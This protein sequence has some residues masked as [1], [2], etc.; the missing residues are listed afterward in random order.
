[1]SYFCAEFPKYINCN[2]LN[3]CIPKCTQHSIIL[4]MILLIGSIVFISIFIYAKLNKEGL[5]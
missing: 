2:S 4:S 5:R 1:M 3:E